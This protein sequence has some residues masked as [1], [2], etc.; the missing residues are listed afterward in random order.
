M[1]KKTGMREGNREG[2]QEGGAFNP[3]LTRRHRRRRAAAAPPPRPLAPAPSR[4]V[5]TRGTRGCQY[6]PTA[7]GEGRRGEPLA[8]QT[9]WRLAASGSA[10]AASRRNPPA[11]GDDLPFQETW[12]PSRAAVCRRRRRRAAPCVRDGPLDLR[13]CRAADAALWGDGT[14]RGGT[15]FFLQRCGFIGASGKG[16]RSEV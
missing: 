7:R 2:G 8:V 3:K 15:L 1:G 9:P 5:A 11:Q 10:P 6:C 14:G 12:Q 16:W 4:S 13:I